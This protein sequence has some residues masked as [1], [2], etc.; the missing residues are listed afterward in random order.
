MLLRAWLLLSSATLVAQDEEAIPLAMVENG[1]RWTEVTGEPSW[2]RKPVACTDRFSF[3]T[4]RRNNRASW[5]QHQ[6]TGDAK[7]DVRN[8]LFDHLQPVFGDAGTLPVLEEMLRQT[9]LVD[10][11]LGNVVVGSGEE[12]EVQNVGCMCWRTPIRSVVETFDPSLQGR[13]EW[14]LL[15]SI[16]HWQVAEEPPA[17][18]RKL[19]QREGFFRCAFASPGHTP[20]Q[21]RL[22]GVS[23]VR[24]NV[25]AHL[26]ELLTPVC[27]RVMAQEAASAAV[28][29]LAPVAKLCVDQ[30][31]RPV[32]TEA[33]LRKRGPKCLAYCLWEVPTEPMIRVLP[34]ADRAAAL[35]ALGLQ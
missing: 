27:G 23:G 3:R 28:D 1:V 4:T 24:S 26:V 17:W 8:L 25:C 7:E 5:I 14:V 12:Q 35:V 16:V 9:V 29:R 13:I 18:A 31:S 6:L 22:A 33:G 15:R 19:P 34:K 21:A 20:K 10:A 2:W 32:K 11:V 30:R